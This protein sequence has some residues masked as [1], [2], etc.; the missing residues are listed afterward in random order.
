MAEELS[1]TSIDG[2][3]FAAARGRLSD[4][5]RDT[6]MFVRDLGPFLEY[7]LLAKSGLLPLPSQAPWLSLN[8]T[9][10]LHAALSHRRH[11]WV[12]PKTRRTGLF[13]TFLTPTVSSESSFTEFCVAAQ[14]A[15]VDAG[16]PRAIAAQLVGAIGEME[17]NIHEHSKAA[18]S[19]VLVFQ[20]TTGTF[21]FVV[22]DRGV[23]VLASLNGC[24]AY[25]A[26]ADHGEALRLTLTDGVTRYGDTANRGHGFRSLFTGLA[27]LN[28]YVRFRSGDHALTIEGDGPTII[29]AKLAKKT[30]TN[31]LF[32]SVR[33]HIF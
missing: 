8:G 19:G 24:P 11:L 15:A 13:R 23:G 30:P 28:G 7:L 29:S 22:A 10:D 17:G 12:C 14:F 18:N 6:K 2:L 20:A 32:A 9:A 21:E 16:F 33:C 25:A 27:N 3:A 31:G 5:P 1:F 26:L 4:I